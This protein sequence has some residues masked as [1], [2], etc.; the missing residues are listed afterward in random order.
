MCGGNARA[1]LPA[2]CPRRARTRRRSGPGPA[3]FADARPAPPAGG[4]KKKAAQPGGSRYD[5]S[6]ALL[7]QRFVKLIQDSPQGNVD[8][9]EAAQQL[10]VQK[11]RIYDITNVLEG[12]GLVEKT[13]KNNIRWRSAT[14]PAQRTRAP[15]PRKLQSDPAIGVRAAGLR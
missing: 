8:L 9:N 14:G 7:T 10:G 15:L 5:N 1:I 13:S 2:L 11:R 4:R 12:I 6:L 3:H